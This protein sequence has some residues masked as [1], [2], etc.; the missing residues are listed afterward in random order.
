MDIVRVGAATLNQIPLDWHGNKKR[1][2]SIIKRAQDQSVGVLCF[3]E[4]AITGYNCEDMFFSLHVARKAV[5]VLQE[6]V[7][8]TDNLVCFIG[9]PIYAKGSMYNCVAVV[10]NK[11]I[12]GFVPKKILPREGVHYESRWFEAWQFGE[13]SQVIVDG[14]YIPFGDLRFEFGRLS[15]GLEICEEAW[16]AN[17]AASAHAQAGVELIVNCS[18]SHFALGKIDVRET[19]VRNASRAMQV[20]YVYTNLVGLENGRLI[21]DGGPMFGQSG[22]IVGYG[23]RFGFGDGQLVIQD[24][25]LDEVRVAKLRNR[26]LTQNFQANI[27][28]LVVQGQKI[29]SPGRSKSI[30]AQ[31]RSTLKTHLTEE[32]EFYWA[33]MLALY[34]YLRKTGSKS[35]IVSLSGG[36]DSGTVAVLIA[37]MITETLAYNGPE[38]MSEIFGVHPQGDVQDPRSWI[39]EMLF[40]VYQATDNSGETTRKAAKSVAEELGASFYEVNIQGVV[41]MYTDFAGSIMERE[42]DWQQDDLTLQNIQARSR[43]PLVWMLANLKQGLLVSTSNRSEAAV[44]YATMDGDTSGGIAPLAGIDKSFLRRW[45]KWAETSCHHGLGPL[46]SLKLINKQQPTAELRPSGAAQ[47]DELDLMPYD[48]LNSIE[49]WLI[50]DRMAPL[51]ILMKLE[52]RYPEIEQNTLKS[53]LRKFLRLWAINQWKRERYAPSFHLDDESLD[54]K[55]WCRF[56]IISSG[57]SSEIEELS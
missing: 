49:K 44:G 38:K 31:Y 37:H 56:P 1:M 10:Q 3:P 28:H 35:Y 53:Y 50:R 43:S 12:I 52:N 16:G 45:L 22:Q 11:K 6:L 47:Q 24:L 8:H 55:T 7:L 36:C 13:V 33:E 42:L 30:E 51:S 54:P 17:G 26:S 48:I 41:D 46:A 5:A 9:L 18:A 29:P 25:D 4:L 21:Y 14:D 15:I 2:L 32:E 39:K 40:L 19:L 27:E 34:D 57:F 23:P 20:H